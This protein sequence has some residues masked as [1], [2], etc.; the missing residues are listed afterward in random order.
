[1]ALIDGFPIDTFYFNGMYIE[2][3]T[4][5]NIPSETNL[6]NMRLKL[7][8]LFNAFNYMNSQALTIR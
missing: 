8:V 2:T 4:P 7:R 3:V 6:K 5:W 1:M